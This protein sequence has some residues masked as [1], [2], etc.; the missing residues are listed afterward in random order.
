MDASTLTAWNNIQNDDLSGYDPS[1]VDNMSSSSLTLSNPGGFSMSM[2]SA[3]SVLRAGSSI[4]GGIGAYMQ[5]QEEAGADEYNASLAL[6]E[7]VFQVQQI[8]K[9]EGQTLSTQKAMY[10]K[11]GVEQSGS[12]LDT[13]LSTATQF[14]Y[15]K[16]V[17][18]YNA[19]SAAN[20]DNYEAAMAKS[21]GKMG[22]AMGLMGGASKLLGV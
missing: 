14:E 11:A 22:L 5:G 4:L 15:S 8:G 21:Q 18:T 13:A 16:Q 1:P 2:P 9:E 7:G 10:A 6:Q 19:Q 17:A 20:V 12:V 3:G